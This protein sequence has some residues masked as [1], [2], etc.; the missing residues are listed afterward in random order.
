MKK[1]TLL[2]L[3]FALVGC[4]SSTA[5]TEDFS[6]EYYKNFPDVPNLAYYL[7]LDEDSVTV[8]SEDENQLVFACTVDESLDIHDETI[9]SYANYARALEADGYSLD[10]LDAT[11]SSTIVLENDS[12]TISLTSFSDME[13]YKE[14]H[15]DDISNTDTLTSENL[16]FELTQK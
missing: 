16:L 4:N 15:A 1:L 5:A 9:V 7:E 12:Y 14:L 10:V 3:L 13:A 8:L 2:V 11:I 6:G